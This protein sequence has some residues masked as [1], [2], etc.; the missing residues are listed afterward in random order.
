MTFWAA[1]ITP[2]EAMTIDLPVPLNLTQAV[3]GIGDG[4]TS[5]RNILTATIGDGEAESQVVVCSLTE[6]V[7]ENFAMNL[8]FAPGKLTMQVTGTM[9]IHIAGMLLFD[10]DEDDM[11]GMMDSDEEEEDLMAEVLDESISEEEESSEEAVVEEKVEPKPS[12]KKRKKA[13]ADADAAPAAE[14]KVEK[15]KKEKK[16]PFDLSKKSLQ[17]KDFQTGTGP[18]AK[19][20]D[21]IFIRY[22]GKLAS[23][24]KMFDSSGGRPFQFSLGAG[25][26]IKGWD[27]G[28]KGMRVGGKRRILIP[29][30]L[31]YGSRGAPPE[32]PPNADLFF[33]LEMMKI[34]TAKTDKKGRRNRTKNRKMKRQGS[35]DL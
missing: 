29:S 9:P 19:K 28:V 3:L 32:I 20:G 15:K 13:E 14:E 33:D 26:V 30:H 7:T 35:P 10:E 11:Y 27:E 5:G 2:K 34:G 25:E 16:Q 4:K 1:I 17:M 18:A 8:L 12:K 6:G 31:A 21:R 24:G 23:T 22:T